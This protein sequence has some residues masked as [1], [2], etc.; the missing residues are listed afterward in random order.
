MALYS[1]ILGRAGDFEAGMFGAV[2]FAG[3]VLLVMLCERIVRRLKRR[4]S[5]PAVPGLVREESSTNN[6]TGP[7]ASRAVEVGRTQELRGF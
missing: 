6:D 5:V 3:P 1:L 4:T 2:I 7:A